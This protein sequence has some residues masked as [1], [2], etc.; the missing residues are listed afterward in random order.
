MTKLKVHSGASKRFTSIFDFAMNAAS[1]G[2]HLKKAV[3]PP[4]F[5]IHQVGSAYDFNG[6]KVGKNKPGQRGHGPQNNEAGKQM[7]GWMCRHSILFTGQRTPER[8]L[9]PS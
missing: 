9:F 5:S 8:H 4:G 2:P 7:Y 1:S 6:F 3:S